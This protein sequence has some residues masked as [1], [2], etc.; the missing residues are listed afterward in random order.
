MEKIE[1]VL[2]EDIS[3][4]DAMMAINGAVDEQTVGLL[5]SVKKEAKQLNE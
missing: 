4:A 5:S 1:S 3:L 2:G